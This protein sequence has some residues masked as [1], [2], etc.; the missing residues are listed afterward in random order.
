[1]DVSGKA[2]R[3]TFELCGETFKTKPIHDINYRLIILEIKKLLEDSPRITL[4]TVKRFTNLTGLTSLD[5][6]ITGQPP[7]G[8][9]FLPNEI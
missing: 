3:I 2:P 8:I 4:Q 5:T 9:R 6:F 1:M 7:T